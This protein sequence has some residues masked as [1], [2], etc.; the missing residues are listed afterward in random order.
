MPNWPLSFLP[1]HL[2]APPVTRAQVWYSPAAS[3]T[4]FVNPSTSTGVAWVL[5][6]PSPSCPSSLAPQQRTDPP[7]L[8]T[9]ACVPP[10]DMPVASVI[11]E[12][13][14]GTTDEF[15]EPSPSRLPLA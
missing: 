8:S 11:P 15:I 7:D 4:T 1:Q 6:V 3:E 14:T 2:T 13:S 9:H 12:T 5:V 10:T